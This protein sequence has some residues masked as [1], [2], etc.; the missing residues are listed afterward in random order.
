MFEKEKEN[1][2][3]PVEFELTNY[4]FETIAETYYATR[5]GFKFGL[6]TTT[7]YIRLYLILL[8]FWIRSTSQHVGVT[9]HPKTLQPSTNI[10]NFKSP[11]KSNS[12]ILTRALDLDSWCQTA[13]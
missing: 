6:K 12:T 11:R 2:N 13:M 9:N 7:L 4:R 8:F 1:I 3:G 10:V 5:L